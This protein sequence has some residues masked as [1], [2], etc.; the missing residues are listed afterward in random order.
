MRNSS[1]KTEIEQEN[2]SKHL[3]SSWLKN[4]NKENPEKGDIYDLIDVSKLMLSRYIKDPAA[5]VEQK[6][7][8]RRRYCGEIVIDYN[9][10]K[11]KLPITKEEIHSIIE[12]FYEVL[13][14]NNLSK[15]K[16]NNT[17]L[18]DDV[19]LYEQCDGEK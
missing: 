9:Y 6:H 15:Y 4:L 8:R 19:D 3:F 11:Q 14:K 16:V 12:F 13:D 10:Y 2:A 7:E 1:S 17:N 18:N 5:L